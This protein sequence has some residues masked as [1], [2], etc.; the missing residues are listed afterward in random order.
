MDKKLISEMMALKI[1]D[2]LRTDRRQLGRAYLVSCVQSFC[3]GRSNLYYDSAVSG[4]CGIFIRT[5]TPRNLIT[6]TSH[7]K[8]AGRAL[9]LHRHLSRPRL[10][11]AKPTEQA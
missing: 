11:S 7:I 8:V 3:F 9:G 10:P 5:A 2:A 4:F 1:D 6:C